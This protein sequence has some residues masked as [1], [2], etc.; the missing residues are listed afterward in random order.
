[1]DQDDPGTLYVLDTFNHALREVVL[2]SGDPASPLVRSFLVYGT[3][4]KPFLAASLRAPSWI[5]PLGQG[6]LVFLDNTALW[7]LHAPTRSVGRILAYDDDA[8][9]A[10]A[11]VEAWP[12]NASVASLDAPWVTLSYPGFRLRIVAVGEPCPQGYTSLLGSDCQIQCPQRS[13]VDLYDGSCKACGVPSCQRGQALRACTANAPAL[14]ED[15]PALSPDPDGH[16]RVYTAAGSC[17]AVGYAPPCPK[18]YYASGGVCLPCP[19][20]AYTELPGA[21]N[22]QACRCRGG[23]PMDLALRLCLIGQLYE[24]PAPSQC[25][26]GRYPPLAHP[27]PNAAHRARDCRYNKGGISACVS[28]REDPCPPCATWE[29]PTSACDCADCQ[30][31]AHATATAPGRLDAP[32]SCQ[33]ACDRGFF[34]VSSMGYLEKCQ[35]CAGLMPGYQWL[36]NG[37]L[38]EAASCQAGCAANY[39]LGPGGACV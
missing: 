37:D 30:L 31:P 15:C 17:E 16:A 12:W 39:T 28:C 8:T 9:F 35:P 33:Y 22:L 11:A 3:P 34:P 1:M 2:P 4:T 26:F 36:T 25:P 10:L 32:N 14:C 6:H 23:F 38:D 7:H 13:Y 29:Y 19:N 24:V 27:N 21:T 18:D 5:R 20:Y